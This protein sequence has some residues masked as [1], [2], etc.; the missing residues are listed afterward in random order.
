MNMVSVH[1]GLA[2]QQDI[3]FPVAERPA[4]WQDKHGNYHATGHKA[5][6]RVSDTKQPVQ[7][8]IVKDSYKVVHNREI[9][10]VVQEVVAPYPHDIETYMDYEGRRCFIDV[11]FKEV[12]KGFGG[13]PVAF[14]TIFWNGYG[15]ASFGCRVGAIN[16]FCLNGMIM[17][18]YETTYKRH[19]SGLDVQVAKEW[20][21]AGL[22]KFQVVSKEWERWLNTSISEHMGSMKGEQ[23]L[24][25]EAWRGMSDN[26]RHHQMMDQTFM[27]K[28]IPKYGETLFAVYNTLTDFAS[29]HENYRL[30]QANDNGRNEKEIR[31]LGKAEKVMREV[32]KMAA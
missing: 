14:R 13:S 10:D 24:L 17:G 1:H 11:T 2:R 8:A 23:K 7:L 19:T 22:S 21:T 16:S 30:R 9:M 27:D 12:T 4:F 26:E 25:T 6:L 3:M 5:L 20:V 29:H 18:E 31:L 32:V 15:G 28:Y